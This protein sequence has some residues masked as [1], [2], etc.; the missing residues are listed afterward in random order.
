MNE[1]KLD[2]GEYVLTVKVD[3]EV[4][5]G[6]GSCVF[7]AP[8]V[9]TQRDEDGVVELLDEHPPLSLEEVVVEAAEVC[10]AQVISIE[11]KPV[12]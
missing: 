11:R 3:Q 7:A 1:T 6:A 8:E 9:F 4:C 2:L 12:E 10:P 5:V